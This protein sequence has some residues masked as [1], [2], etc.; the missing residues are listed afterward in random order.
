[1]TVNVMLNYI[2]QAKGNVLPSQHVSFMV[3]MTFADHADKRQT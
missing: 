2:S 3:V 1:M